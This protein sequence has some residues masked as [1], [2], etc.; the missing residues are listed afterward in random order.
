MKV[1]DAFN[2]VNGGSQRTEHMFNVLGKRTADSMAAGCVRLAS[3]WASAWKE[4]QGNKLAA[5]KL[6]AADRG[7][8]KKLYNKNS[9]L[10]A[11]RLKDPQFQAALS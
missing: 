1:I 8:L 2:A 11:F 10:E 6:G 4:G 3:I 7:E 9:F 5:T